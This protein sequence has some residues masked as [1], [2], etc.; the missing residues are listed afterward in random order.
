M[1]DNK[2]EILQEV[3]SDLM[4]LQGVIELAA[5]AAETRRVLT[6]VY[7]LTR[8]N[9]EFQKTMQGIGGWGTFSDMPDSLGD[10]LMQASNG[11]KKNQELIDRVIW[12][13]G[14]A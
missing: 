13:G 1:T 7:D 9:P 11:I 6:E 2:T 4:Q 5:F 3:V 12:K 14:K 8:I 10:V